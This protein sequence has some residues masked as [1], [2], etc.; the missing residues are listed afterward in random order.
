MIDLSRIKI[1]DSQEMPVIPNSVKDEGVGLVSTFVDDVLTVAP[2]EGGG[3]EHFAGIS[4]GFQFFPTTKVEV[5]TST[6][7]ATGSYVLNT[8]PN[9]VAS[10]ISIFDVT[11][12]VKLNEDVSG[13]GNFQV[14]DLTGVVT[15]HS[16]QAGH[17]VRIIYKFYPTVIELVSDGIVPNNN[18]LGIDGIDRI[19]VFK[20][21]TIYTDKFDVTVDW[22]SRPAIVLEAGGIFSTATA[23]TTVNATIISIPTNNDPFLGLELS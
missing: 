3:S 6:I 11:G 19:G 12:N 23:G 7:P 4:Y 8:K 18:S 1:N 2:A 10:Q 5:V 16:A 22:A 9:L 15:F 13:S 21:G 17:V 14:D 20:K